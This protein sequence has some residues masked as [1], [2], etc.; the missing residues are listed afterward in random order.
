M[1]PINSQTP[2][3]LTCSQFAFA[4]NEDRSRINAANGRMVG[5][6]ANQMWNGETT[7]ANA[8][9]RLLAAS[10]TCLDKAGRI[11]GVDPAEL[12]EKLDIAALIRAAQ[13]ARLHLDDDVTRWALAGVLNKLP[14]ID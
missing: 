6:T 8:D 11:L 13:T 12:A 5:S 2:G 10:Y 7:Q 14:K 9:A 3:P 4:D 1:N